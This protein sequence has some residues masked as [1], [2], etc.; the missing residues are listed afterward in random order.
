MRKETSKQ[1]DSRILGKMKELPM[2]DATWE[3]EQV[4]QHPSLQLLED[5]QFQVG[6]IVMSSSN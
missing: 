4:L 3:G 5:K 2:E 1:G 6:R